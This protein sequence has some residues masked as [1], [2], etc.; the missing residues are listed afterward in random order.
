MQEE[1]AR[2]HGHG[3]EQLYSSSPGC[4]PGQADSPVSQRGRGETDPG[5]G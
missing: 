1:R 4:S 3:D 2:G 5:Q